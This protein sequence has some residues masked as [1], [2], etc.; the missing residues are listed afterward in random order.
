ME[1]EQILKYDIKQ[2]LNLIVVGDNVEVNEG[3]TRLKKLESESVYEQLNNY[4][5][6]LREVLNSEI[7]NVHE[8]PKIMVWFAKYLPEE[9]LTVHLISNDIATMLRNTEISDMSHLT[10]ILQVLLDHSIY[11][12]DSINHA[13]LCEAIII[14]L[15]NFS[16]SY[17][18]KK[19]LEFNDNA[20]KVQ[21]FLKMVQTRSKNIENNNLIFTCLQT[22]YRIIS[23]TKRKQDPGPG[24]AAVL[25]VVEPSIIPQAV[26]WILSESHCDSQLTQALKVLC[27]WL[28]K[29]RGDRLSIWIM[30]FILGL[31]KQHKYSILMEVTKA[32]L[33]VLF[34]ALSVPV[35][36][37]NA[38]TIIFYV[39]K[40]QGHPS[41]FRNIVRNTQMILSYL[42]KEDSE[43]SKECIQNLVD[44]TKTLMLRFP[45]LSVFNNLENSL[46]VPPRMHIVKELWT[47][48]V[49]VDEI[50]EVEPVIEPLKPHVEKVGLSNL[51]NTCYMNSVLQALLMTKRF[52]YEVLMYKP[53]S[54]T[55]DQVVLKKLQNLFTLLLY[56]KRITLAPTEI[57]L[58][59]RPAYFL[60]GQQQDSS[61]FLWLI[62]C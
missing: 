11:L 20:T 55:D 35:I 15:S 54:K 25:Q 8:V 31:E 41:L 52:C 21:Y 23:D 39:L 32:S 7:K 57:L 38:S 34:C 60:P 13:K 46:P 4:E 9:P 18:P 40:R 16:M 3:W 48:H 19:I 58:A 62:C 22:L 12:P 36:R 27:S 17:E 6:I 53:L 30:E 28:P 14:S 29:W 49:W 43:S 5:S 37:Q 24:L 44:I 59:S 26:L 33:D 2:C 56:S 50:E 42:T 1:T 45:G 47:E 10:M 51:G 61:E